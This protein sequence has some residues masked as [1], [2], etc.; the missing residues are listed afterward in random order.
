MSALNAPATSA[1]CGAMM[2]HRQMRSSLVMLEPIKPRPDKA[3]QQERR[4]QRGRQGRQ[5]I[6]GKYRNDGVRG[7]ACPLSAAMTPS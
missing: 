5:Q 7:R 3:K 6:T 2:R 4:L 1:T